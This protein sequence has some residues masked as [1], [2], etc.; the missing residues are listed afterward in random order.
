MADRQVGRD[1]RRLRQKIKST[2]EKELPPLTK[3]WSKIKS[4]SEKEL[5]SLP[6]R[7]QGWFKNLTAKRSN[8]KAL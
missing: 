2:S 5:P 4:T 8:S 7:G 1:T 3:K 6:R